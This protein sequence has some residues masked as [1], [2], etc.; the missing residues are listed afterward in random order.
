DRSWP[1]NAPLGDEASLKRPPGVRLS[2][3]GSFHGT[4]IHL[5][6]ESL[7]LAF[8]FG[9]IAQAVILRG[10]T[11]ARFF[12]A[13]LVLG[14]LRE[15]FVA[16]H[17]ILSTFSALHLRLGRAPLLASIIWGFS[18]YAAVVWAETVSGERFGERRL[19]TLFLALVALFMIA[20]ACFYEPFLA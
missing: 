14:F 17:D 15:S 7:T 9:L 20:L 3:E 13:L 11:G 1:R 2:Q 19:S 10:W 16:G 4:V 5:F 6:V 8:L 12:A 18:I